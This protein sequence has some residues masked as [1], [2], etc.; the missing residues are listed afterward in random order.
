MPETIYYTA[1]RVAIGKGH[2]GERDG[3]SEQDF[4]LGIVSTIAHLPDPEWERLPVPVQEWCNNACQLHNIGQP[5]PLPEGYKP[6]PPPPA[7]VIPP[8]PPPP[9]PP[10]PPDMHEGREPVE[11]PRKTRE[12]NSKN[13]GILD[14]IRKTVILNPNW[15]ARQ[16]HEYLTLNGYPDTKQPIVAVNTGDV[17]R[18]ITLARELGFWRD[19]Q[20][21]NRQ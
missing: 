14:A 18:V 9:S 11:A 13:A 7:V 10:P 1:L 6:I 12:K 16:V 2:S 20:Y 19:E 21:A 8:P 15:T 17:K 5:I 4:L 3:K